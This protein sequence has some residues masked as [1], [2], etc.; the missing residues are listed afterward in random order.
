[1]PRLRDAEA[2][3]WLLAVLIQVH[4]SLSPGRAAPNATDSSTASR[5]QRCHGF[6]KAASSNFPAASA[7]WNDRAACSYAVGP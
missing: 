1:V 2:P 5:P 3:G 4:H 7:S 6:Q